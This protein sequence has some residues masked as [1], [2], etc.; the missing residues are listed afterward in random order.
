[1]VLEAINTA[2][3]QRAFVFA[4]TF[5]VVF[6]VLI[7]SVPTGLL[8]LGESPDMIT[9]LDSSIITG[10]SESETYNKSDFSLVGSVYQYLYDLGSRTWLCQQG[11]GYF[12]LGAK[13]FIGGILWLGQLDS[14]AFISSDG[15]D[16]S[17][18]LTF[19]EIDADA[20]DGVIRYT[21]RY[22]GTGGSAGGFVV[23]WNTTTYSNSSAAWTGGELYLLHGMG[24]EDTANADI[25]ALLISLLLLQLPEVP[26][27][28]NVLLVVPIWASIIFVLWYII[29]EMIPFV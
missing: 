13:V 8:G 27:L 22:V 15:V 28:I 9:P 23:Y 4:V 3:E 20:E 11:F 16:R 18:S 17:H 26:V 21:L 6:S 2:S 24:I 5:I 7:A 10:F 25:G 14:C 19:T 29:K 1:M 12:Q